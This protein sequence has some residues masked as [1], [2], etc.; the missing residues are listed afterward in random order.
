[1]INSPVNDLFYSFSTFLTHQLEQLGSGFTNVG[2]TYY[3]IN[4]PAL[5]QYS[6]YASPYKQIVSDFSISG[7]NIPTG[8]FVNGQQISRG[9][10]GLQYIDYVNNR[11]IFSGGMNN[12]Q[13]SGNYSL[14]DFNIYTTT[15]SDEELIYETAFQLRPSYV[16]PLTGLNRDELT[17]PGIFITNS[18]F[19]NETYA[20][21]GLIETII[22]IHCIVL[23]NSKDQLDAAGSILTDQKYNSF[24]IFGQTQIPFNYFGDYRAFL[25]GSFN[26]LNYVDTISQPLAY[27]ADASYY[28]LS[29]RDFSNRYPDLRAA[30]VDFNI[31]Y[32][33]LPNQR[34]R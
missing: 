21:G 24:P 4:D 7:V 1:M 34:V 11:M 12:L 26:Y 9:I 27:I 25:S 22:N 16:V 5:P 14:R 32:V 17:V 3:N 28:K 15:T 29:N 2:S 30:F 33:R 18:N 31:R 8:C 10:S 13:V 20:F 6:I 23:T 19:D